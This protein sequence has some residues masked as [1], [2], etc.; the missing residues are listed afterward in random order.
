VSQVA[1]RKASTY[2][3]FLIAGGMLAIGGKSGGGATAAAGSASPRPKPDD[4]Y[5]VNFS[6][7]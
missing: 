6:F 7:F 2:S 3:T 5:V 1:T 4:M